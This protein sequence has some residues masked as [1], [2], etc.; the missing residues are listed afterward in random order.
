MKVKKIIASVS[1]A[2]LI[3]AAALPLSACGKGDEKAPLDISKYAV[4]VND[5]KDLKTANSDFD[6]FGSATSLGE[7]NA[8]QYAADRFAICATMADSKTTYKAINT[9]TGETIANSERNITA[10]NFLG[11][12]TVVLTNV[13]D[14]ATPVT[15]KQYVGEDGKT[16]C[17][18]KEAD[19]SDIQADVN[20]Y[21]VNGATEKSKVLSVIYP[22]ENDDIE[23]Y[24]QI[25]TDEK[26]GAAKYTEV[27]KNN[28]SVTAPEY[29]AGATPFVAKKKIYDDAEKPVDGDMSAY[30]YAQVGNDMVF[31]N[32]GNE[33]G[34]IN[35]DNVIDLGYDMA[36]Q[37]RKP[38]FVGNYWYYAVQVSLSTDAKKPDI[39]YSTEM[40]DFKYSYSIHKYDI[41]NQKD[42]VVE[43]DYYVS[44]ITPIYNY[45]DKKF[46][47]AAVTGSR[48][49]DG[50]V[51]STK[52]FTYVTDAT[53]T[54]A[55]DVSGI[56]NTLGAMSDIVD[57]G[58]EKY[59]VVA[60]GKAV[61]ID[62]DFNPISVYNSFSY[63]Y[64][65]K[66]NVVVF[67][68]DGNEG[69]ADID[70]KVLA[71]PKYDMGTFFGGKVFAY[72]N[73][74][75]KNVILDANGT[76]TVIDKIHDDTVDMET[77]SGKITDYTL[78]ED[79]GV[80]YISDVVAGKSTTTIYNLDGSTITSFADGDFSGASDI[81]NKC[82]KI[83]FTKEVEG[84]GEV[85][86][87]SLY[88][89]G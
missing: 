68:K 82:F 36:S 41:I 61:V 32:G 34:K 73:V 24:Y 29:A 40:G 87:Y 28:L 51:Q 47:A 38:A 7:F 60:D 59:A 4:A 42:E 62:K 76:E 46:D 74:T 86:V 84:I 27:Q 70:G 49:V 35:L 30:S 3:A 53:L 48:I 33:V 66:A 10:S 18:V 89:L 44:Y 88:Y 1:C 14:D 20:E 26:T 71:E 65:V 75:G 58:S 56:A 37:S 12:K 31:Y 57:L 50:V 43:K 81:S 8:I 64:Y 15:Y 11:V 77:G 13:T 9:V 79:Y 85:N 19:V 16:L 45:A 80:Y 69:L 63:N 52:G 17:T 21:Y 55:Y 2:A 78:A 6:K 5:W 83:K 72:N 54:K 25:E 23:K 39:I 22:G 67:N